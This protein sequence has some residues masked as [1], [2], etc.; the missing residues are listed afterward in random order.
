M[1]ESSR[2][3]CFPGFIFLSAGGVGCFVAGISRGIG[4]DSCPAGTGR[5]FPGNS[6]GA[7]GGSLKE[8]EMKYLFAWLLGVPGILIVIWFLLNHS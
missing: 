5:C 7:G 4:G 2:E 3:L 1:N 8:I 6:S